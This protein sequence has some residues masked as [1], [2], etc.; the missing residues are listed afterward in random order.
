[1]KATITLTEEQISQLTRV[2]TEQLIIEKDKK[3]K[4]IEK[5]F[6][7]ALLKLKNKYT[8]IKVDIDNE[9]E[10]TTSSRFIPLKSLQI[11]KLSD[12]TITT[13]FNEGKSLKEM[14]ELTGRS[15][16]Q[17]RAKLNRLGLKIRDRK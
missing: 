3:I 11:S 12:E 9:E 2:K 14:S 1:M 15:D 8:T 17:I 5:E 7:S 13:Y 10:E 16:S 4:A 6:E